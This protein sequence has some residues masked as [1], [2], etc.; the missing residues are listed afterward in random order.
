MMRLLIIVLAALPL[1][2]CMQTFQSSVAGSCAVFERPPYAV[3]GKTEYD[4][5]VADG[6]VESGVAGCN[7]RRPAPR[8]PELDAP[9]R[10]SVKSAA[11]PPRGKAAFSRTRA[12]IT[13]GV[14]RVWPSGASAPVVPTPAPPVATPSAVAPDP[15]PPA[16]RPLTPLERLLR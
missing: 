1:G 7:W 10:H 4:Q 8:P 9:R 16:A 14:R 11:P 6:F 2:A 3:I 15:A 5:R 12:N 13:A